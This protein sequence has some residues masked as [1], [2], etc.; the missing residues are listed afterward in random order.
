M[1]PIRMKTMKKRTIICSVAVVALTL[2]SSLSVFAQSE[3]QIKRF[4]EERKKYFTTKLEL[5]PEESK[6]FWP[7]YN[8][9]QNRKMKFMDEEKTIYRYMRENSSNLDD[10]E[11]MKNLERVLELKKEVGTLEEEYYGDKF[12]TILPPAKVMKL[13]MLE[14]DFRRHLMREIRGRGQ[15]G[16]GKN[17]GQGRRNQLPDQ[18]E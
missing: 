13:Y 6:A 12:P 14:S 16:Q 15:D 18:A 2:I 8:D 5:T 11:I 3:E 7:M 4:K 1:N 17:R 9:L 10:S